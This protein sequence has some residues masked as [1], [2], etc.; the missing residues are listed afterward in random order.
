MKKKFYKDVLTSLSASIL[1][2]GAG[3]DPALSK[4]TGIDTDQEGSSRIRTRYGKTI[5][6]L[7]EEEDDSTLHDY[8]FASSKSSANSYNSGKSTD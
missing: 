6:S 1:L 3:I 7:S 8:T 2:T 4:E 5:F